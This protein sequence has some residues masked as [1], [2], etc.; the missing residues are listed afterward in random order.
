MQGCLRVGCDSVD[1]SE[2]SLVETEAVADLMTGRS[3]LKKE[4]VGYDIVDI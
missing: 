2:V 1:A 4:N 3:E